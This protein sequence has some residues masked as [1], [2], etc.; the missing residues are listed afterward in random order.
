MKLVIPNELELISCSLAEDDAMDGPEWSASDT[1]A[2]GDTVRYA[3]VTYESLADDNSGNIPSETY[4]GLTAYWQK[5]EATGPYKM[6]DEYVETQTCADTELTFSVPFNRASSFAL[7][8]MEGVRLTASVTDDDNNGD[9][10]W[11]V[12]VDLLKDI[13][14]FSLYQ[15]NYDLLEGKTVYLATQITQAI[16]GTLSVTLTAGDGSQAKVGKVVVGPE[17]KIGSTQYDAEIGITDYSKKSVNDFGVT[18]LVKRSFAN[19]MS[20]PVYLHPER[21]DVVAEILK[22]ARG[23]PCLFIGANDDEAYASLTVYGWIDDWRIVLNGPNECQL[24]LE[25]QGLV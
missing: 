4:S 22:S 11:S 15:Y 6:L 13:D 10:L 7:L 23:T 1:Y 8:N 16:N 18:T 2:K 5:G 17:R 24:S 25:I 14:D 3:H 19:E 21:M 20:L 9:V 12:D